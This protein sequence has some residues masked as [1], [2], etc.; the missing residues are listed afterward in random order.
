V[1]IL[2]QDEGRFGRISDRRRCWAPLPSR[3]LVGHQVIREYVYAVTAVSPFG[4]KIFSLV[5]P[6][7]D[8][9]GMSVF[10]RHTAQ[11]FVNEVCIMILDGAGWHRANNL[12]VPKTIRL[13]PLPP[14]SPELNPVEHIWDWLRDNIFK[15][16]AFE[17]LDE[18]MDTLC[19]ALKNLSVRPDLVKSLTCF[20]WLNALSLTYN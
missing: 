19:D 3:P 18:V 14:Y 12:Q 4:G 20:E 8:A 11:A 16:M 6:W 15:N 13:V 2:F 7:V 1:R 17:S 10:L 9:E 5:L